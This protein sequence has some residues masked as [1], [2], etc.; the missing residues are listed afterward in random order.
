MPG[1]FPNVVKDAQRQKLTRVQSGDTSVVSV[2]QVKGQS[3]RPGSYD[4]PSRLRATMNATSDD[5]QRN[6]H[7]NSWTHL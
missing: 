7:V 5:V 3:T 4:H 6:R 2:G 1:S